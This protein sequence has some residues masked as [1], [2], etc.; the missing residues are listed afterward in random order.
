MFELKWRFQS[1]NAILAHFSY[2][3][4]DGYLTYKNDD[5]EVILPAKIYWINFLTFRILITLT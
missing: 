3:I 2:I 4:D 5:D 1:S